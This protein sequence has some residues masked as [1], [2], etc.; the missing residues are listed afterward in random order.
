L[1][2][3]VPDSGSCTSAN[4]C[5]GITNG[6]FSPAI[7]APLQ[8]PGMA[9]TEMQIVTKGLVCMEQ[10]LMELAHMAVALLE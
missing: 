9:Y 3:T 2:I 5:F 6:G 1:A 8:R 10:T 7:K 4:P